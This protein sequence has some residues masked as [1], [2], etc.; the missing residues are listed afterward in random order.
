LVERIEASKDDL[1]GQLAA[2]EDLHGLVEEID[3]AIS[4]FGCAYNALI[5]GRHGELELVA[6]DHWQGR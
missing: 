3:H 2:F 5:T 6:C 1:E 4:T